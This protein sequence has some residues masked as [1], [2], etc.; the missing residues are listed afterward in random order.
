MPNG[1]RV[2]ADLDIETSLS[3]AVKVAR[4]LTEKHSSTNEYIRGQTN[5]I[6]DLFGLPTDANNYLAEAI[7]GSIPIQ[8]VMNDLNALINGD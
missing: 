1:W 3:A 6:V 7:D 4:R 8:Q 2:T 5:L